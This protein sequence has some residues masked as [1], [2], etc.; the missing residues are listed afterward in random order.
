VHHSRRYVRIPCTTELS[1]T[2]LQV[3]I[4]SLEF[5]KR[6]AATKEKERR[7]REKGKGKVKQGSSSTGPAKASRAVVRE[8]RLFSTSDFFG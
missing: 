8:S 3:H 4:P 5:N 1:V 6:T 7:A 2:D